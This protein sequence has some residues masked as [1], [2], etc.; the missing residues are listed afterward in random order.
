MKPV[1]PILPHNAI[2]CVEFKTFAS[3]TVSVIFNTSHKN[4]RHGRFQ[5]TAL[6]A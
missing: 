3:V 5:R 2:F 4:V 6:S 1:E